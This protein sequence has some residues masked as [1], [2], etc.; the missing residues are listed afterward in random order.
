VT[1]KTACPPHTWRIAIANGPSSEG[2][3]KRCCEKRLF[4]NSINGAYDFASAY[5]KRRRKKENAST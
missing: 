1:T 3:C 2:V 4:D 5:N